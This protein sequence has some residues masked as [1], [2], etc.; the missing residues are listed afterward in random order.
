M[1]YLADPATWVALGK[2]IWVNILLSGDNAVVIALAARATWPAAA[3]HGRAR[4]Q[5][6]GDHPAGVADDLRGRAMAYPYLKIVG[7]AA[8]LD[9]RVTYCCRGGQRGRHRVAADLWAIR[10]ILVAD[11]VMS[12][13]NV[14]AVA[15]AARA[16]ADARLPLLVV[17]WGCRSRSSSSA[18]SC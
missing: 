8:V 11:L 4:R 17:G 15:A 3:A 9:R 1:G 2:I 10:T 14:I 16:A 5:R 13:D 12:L 7:A 6:R 18:A